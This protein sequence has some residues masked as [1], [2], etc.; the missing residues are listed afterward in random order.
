VQ[1]APG[2]ACAQWAANAKPGAGELIAGFP[3]G[4]YVLALGCETPP[5]GAM[6]HLMEMSVKL[7]QR[8][9]GIQLTPAQAQKYVQ[10]STEMMRSVQSMRM[11]LGVA[12]P[13]VTGQTRYDAFGQLRQLRQGEWALDFER[14]VRVGDF[15]LPEKLS[16]KGREVKLKLVVEDWAILR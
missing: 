3:A 13:S 7:M 2:G 15:V 10:L 16:V 4:P 5:S 14:Y 12:E 8:Q 6:E 1:F 9:P 11:V